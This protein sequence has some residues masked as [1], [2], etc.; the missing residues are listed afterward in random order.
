MG[1]VAKWAVEPAMP[2][3]FLVSGAVSSTELNG[4]AR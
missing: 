1:G 2:V 3:F 4:Q